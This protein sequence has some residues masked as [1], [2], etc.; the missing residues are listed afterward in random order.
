MRHLPSKP[1]HR[2]CLVFPLLS[3]SLSPTS[4]FTTSTHHLHPHIGHLI[5]HS[6]LL[7]LQRVLK[8][9]NHFSGGQERI[10]LSSHV[11]P[12]FFRH[13]LAV[14]HRPFYC[15]TSVD[16]RERF[17]WADGDVILR[18]SDMFQYPCHQ[19]D[20]RHH[21]PDMAEGWRPPSASLFIHWCARD[22]QLELLIGGAGQC[23]PAARSRFRQPPLEC[24][25]LRVYAIA[26]Q[27]GCEDG[28]KIASSC[29]TSMGLPGLIELPEELRFI[30]AMEY[31]REVSQRSRGHC[32][33]LRTIM[34]TILVSANGQCFKASYCQNYA[35]LRIA[36]PLSG[37]TGCCLLLGN[38][39][40]HVPHKPHRLESTSRLVAVRFP[41]VRIRSLYVFFFRG[42]I[43][44]SLCL[45]SITMLI[46]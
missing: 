10:S 2:T 41:F 32:Q 35:P 31:H 7:V 9:L 38:L 26:C 19:P 34:G 1:S 43:S 30:P 15:T 27:L 42:G 33:G 4:Y 28:M 13:P 25:P 22:Y 14:V 18:T 45:F 44:P 3:C 29:L 11:S 23:I 20:R 17:N 12:H 5:F 36:R 16:P 24:E 46:F 8:R 37:R 40:R 6:I 21:P 39:V